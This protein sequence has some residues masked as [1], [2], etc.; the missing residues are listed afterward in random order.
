MDAI[1]KLGA[2]DFIGR[3]LLSGLGGDF[4]FSTVQGGGGGADALG[5]ANGREQ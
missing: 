3:T 4:G 1:I 2:G 5:E